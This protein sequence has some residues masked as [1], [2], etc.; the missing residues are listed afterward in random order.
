[1]NYCRFRNSIPEIELKVDILPP[2]RDDVR[3]SVPEYR[4]KLYEIVD[5]A[6]EKDLHLRT[7]NNNGNNRYLYD[8]LIYFNNNNYFFII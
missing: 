3:L 6:T 8:I 2:F 7:S 1:M 5:I 4:S